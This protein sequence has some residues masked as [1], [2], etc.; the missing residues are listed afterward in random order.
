MKYR[1]ITRDGYYQVQYKMFLFW[2][3]KGFRDYTLEKAIESV[4][5]WV[6][7][8]D[9]KRESGKVVYELDTNKQ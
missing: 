4:A 1:V 3:D 7:E 5:Y 2:V 9:K 8:D 6:K